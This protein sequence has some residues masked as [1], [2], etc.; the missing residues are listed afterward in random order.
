MAQEPPTAS[1]APEHNHSESP[2]QTAPHTASNRILDGP[3]Y[4]RASTPPH[5]NLFEDHTFNYAPSRGLRRSASTSSVESIEALGWEV[6]TS[7]RP[8]GY[9]KQRSL[10]RDSKSSHDSTP[11][12]DSTSK[13]DAN[14]L[15]DQVE[16]LDQRP[17][18]IGGYA[19]VSLAHWGS[20]PYQQKTVCIR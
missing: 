9:R 4:T 8:E 7:I 13:D 20:C 15:T 19:S 12:D 5:H 2:A 16:R 14:N 1:A 10:S 3:L 6:P 11:I 18:A 17:I